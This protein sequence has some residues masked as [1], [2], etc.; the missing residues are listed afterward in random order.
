MRES[1]LDLYGCF[2]H[3]FSVLLAGNGPKATACLRCCSWLNL[4]LSS[5]LAHRSHSL[6]AWPLSVERLQLRLQPI[7]LPTHRLEPRHQFGH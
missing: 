7:V 2:L 3:P 1:R 4:T 5:A 6:H